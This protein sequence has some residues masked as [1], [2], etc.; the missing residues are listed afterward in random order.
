MLRKTIWRIILEIKLI[1]LASNKS[2]LEEQVQDNHKNPL[3]MKD[4]PSPRDHANIRH[5]KTLRS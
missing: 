5:A 2:I 4:I 3:V 1:V